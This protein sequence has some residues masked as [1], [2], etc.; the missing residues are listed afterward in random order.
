[1]AR[2][3]LVLAGR[4]CHPARECRPLLLIESSV[5]SCFPTCEP[6][7]VCGSA[8]SRRCAGTTTSDKLP[9]VFVGDEGLARGP[10]D[11]LG[12]LLHEAAHALADVRGIKDTSR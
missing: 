1:M 2:Q 3:H 7:E 11:V 10:A 6:P 12:T 4:S 9:E 5:V 8:T